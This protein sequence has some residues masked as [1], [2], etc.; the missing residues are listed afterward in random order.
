[1]RIITAQQENAFKK[2][3]KMIAEHDECQITFKDFYWGYCYEQSLFNDWSSAND[4]DDLTESEKSWL[5]DI[6]A[7]GFTDQE[8]MSALEDGQFLAET[9]L[10][11][12][13]VENIH[14]FLKG[15]K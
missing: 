12:Q 7:E 9:E 13:E 6:R 2:Y 8:I 1:M 14:S 5:E 11:Q 4:Q 3:E 10:T 15:E